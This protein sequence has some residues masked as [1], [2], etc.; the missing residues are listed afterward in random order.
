M[1]AV[2]SDPADKPR[3]VTNSLAEPDDVE[4]LVA[5]MELA[6]EIAAT[7]PLAEIG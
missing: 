1:A 4:S 7:G 2:S 6:R 3:I 5:G